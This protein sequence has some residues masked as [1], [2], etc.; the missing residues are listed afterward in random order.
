MEARNIRF[1]FS[2]ISLVLTTG[3]LFVLPS[4][5]ACNND[6]NCTTQYDPVCG[7]D[8]KTYS[9]SCMA[10]QACVDAAYPGVCIEPQS[11]CQDLDND[12]YSPNGGICGPI[13]CN[14]QD[15]YINPG[16]IC[17]DIYDPVCGVDGTTYSNS[18]YAL[19]ACVAINYPGECINPPTITQAQYNARTKQLEIIATSVLGQ[20]DELLV[21]GFEAME[22]VKR[23]QSWVLKV[24]KLT[25]DQ[26]PAMITVNG[27]TGSST[28]EV[29]T[30]P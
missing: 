16:M 24:R 28:A 8:G 3:W 10:E 6:F 4:V 17:L 25:P 5:F 29:M 11:A 18:C 7:S 1:K 20:N 15:P 12:N 26:V 9:N 2:I 14:D 30:I 23:L 19:A 13:D 22:W 21:E 27:I